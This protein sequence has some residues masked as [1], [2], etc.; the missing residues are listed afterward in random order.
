MGILVRNT[1]DCKIS[2][3]FLYPDFMACNIITQ[4]GLRKIVVSHYE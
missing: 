3:A 4:N 2:A 1:F